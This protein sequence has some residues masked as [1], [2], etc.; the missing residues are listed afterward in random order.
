MSFRH[1]LAGR[2]VYDAIDERDRRTLHERAGRVLETVT[3][4]PLAQLARHFRQSG[5]VV[6]EKGVWLWGADLVPARV[7][8]LLAVGA[9]AQ[10]QDLVDAFARGLPTGRLPAPRAAVLDCRGLLA[11]AAGDH[12]S[13]AGLFGRA[14][15]AWAALPR[16]YGAAL[17]RERQAGC[18]IRAGAV[19]EGLDLLTDVLDGLSSLPASLDVDRVA[20]CRCDQSRPQPS[21][22]CRRRIPH[23]PSGHGARTERQTPPRRRK[24]HREL[25]G[26]APGRHH[27]HGQHQGQG[28]GRR[29]QHRRADRPRRLPPHR[30]LTRCRI[31][32]ARR[33]RARRAGTRPA[34]GGRHRRTVRRGHPWPPA[35]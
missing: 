1:V 10:A 8:A 15:A 29:R 32:R 28:G 20:T 12:A 35:R 34:E 9:T 31:R 25:P 3:P 2:A 18:L 13:A 16:P 22:P 6:A 14:A 19:P 17:S 4:R 7:Q 11:E 26:P 30:A 33:E 21:H 24:L 23:A 5:E 27:G